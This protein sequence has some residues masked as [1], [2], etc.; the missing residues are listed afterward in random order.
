[1]LRSM[2]NYIGMALM[3]VFAIMVI[4]A[5]TVDSGSVGPE[6][7]GMG[8]MV[9]FDASGNEVFAQSVHNLVTDQGE[10]YLIDAV[11]QEGTTAVAENLSIAS[12][13]ITD[14]ITP[15]LT[16]GQ[17]AVQFELDNTIQTGLNCI[18][19]TTVT[20][21]GDGKAVIG[22]LTF[23]T[24]NLDAADETIG[25]IGICQA[26]SGDDTHNGCDSNS[27]ILFATVDISDTQIGS[28][29]TVQITYTFDISAT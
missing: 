18:E 1:M 5:A 15:T 8:S 10:E 16:D 28:G 25:A 14:D 13:C 24:A 27:G 2:Y 7:W 17:T 6:F 9:L 29:E 12:I 11:F 22:P 26:A 20:Q 23:G 19:A 3:S 4:P 21:A